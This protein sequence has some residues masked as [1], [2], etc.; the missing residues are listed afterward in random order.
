MSRSSAISNG[1]RRISQFAT[2]NS[3]RGRNL[4]YLPRAFTEYGAI[5]AANIL[6]FPR[7]ISMSVYVVRAFVRIREL[8]G[9]NKALADKLDELDRKYQSHDKTIAT[10][11]SAIRQLISPPPQG[12]RGIGF[13]ADLDERS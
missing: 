4:K 3:G 11:L 1:F 7:A 9:S 10:M 13:T 8:Q 6:N 2:L 5:Q 12:K